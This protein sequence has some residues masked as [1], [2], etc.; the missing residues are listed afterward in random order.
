[1]QTHLSDQGI[2]TLIHYPIPIHLQPAYSF[3]EYKRGDFPVTEEV[4]GTILSL[5]LYPGISDETIVAVAE[6]VN[7][8]GA[9]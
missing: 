6:A 7:S 2:G 3:L 8:F 4:A 9:A 5:P 1:L